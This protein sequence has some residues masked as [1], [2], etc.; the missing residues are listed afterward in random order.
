MRVLRDEPGD[1]AQPE[2]GAEPVDQMRQFLAVV[3]AG[4]A[5]L[6]RIATLGDESCDPHH[7]V[8][9]A[10][11]AGVAKHSQPI[12]KQAARPRRIAQR[13]AGADLQPMHLAVGAKQ[14]HLD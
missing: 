12:L 8:A 14:R 1:A 4:E 9:E 6:H 10:R 5:G 13:R 7:V 3:G 11:I 2:A